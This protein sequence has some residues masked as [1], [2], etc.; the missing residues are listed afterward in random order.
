M[1]NAIHAAIL[2]AHQQLM[3]SFALGDAMGVAAIYTEDGQVLPAYSA[4]IRG[5]AAI[6]AFWQGCMDIGICAMQRT[7]LEMDCL[8]A[9]INEVGEYRFLDRHG[10]V[11]DV[12]KYVIIW[13]HHHGQWQI[14]CDI[15]TSSL[16][17]C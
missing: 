14:Q 1:M 10:R 11:L 17:A 9:T 13:K 6:Q 16:P 3:T 15:W 7:A 8:A 2:L 4:A 5:R 12:G